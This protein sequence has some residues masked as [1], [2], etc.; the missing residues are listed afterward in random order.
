MELEGLTHVVYELGRDF[1][2][3][4]FYSEFGK[5]TSFPQIT[6]DNIRLGGCQETI[7]YLQKENVC[8]HA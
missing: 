2:E 6:L 4:E 1:T 7:I 3:E 8:C 5:G